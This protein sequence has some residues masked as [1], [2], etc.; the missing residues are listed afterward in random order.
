MPFC[1]VEIVYCRDYAPVLAKLSLHKTKHR[2]C[3]NHIHKNIEVTPVFGVGPDDTLV[4][5]NID[6]TMRGSPSS[7]LLET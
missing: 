5:R 6:T 2:E 3:A 1:V 4:K 7:S